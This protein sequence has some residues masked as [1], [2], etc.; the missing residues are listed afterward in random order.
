MKALTQDAGLPSFKSR[1]A[2]PSPDT[3]VTLCAFIIMMPA[4]SCGGTRPERRSTTKI[5]VV[6]KRQ[7]RLRYKRSLSVDK[8][9]FVTSGGRVSGDRRKDGSVRMSSL[10]IMS[11]CHG[12]HPKTMAGDVVDVVVAGEVVEVE[13]ASEALAV[14]R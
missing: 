2:N 8:M 5:L 1:S 14:G 13:G 11:L 12:M 7:G 9:S 10:L 4:M 3:S 6:T